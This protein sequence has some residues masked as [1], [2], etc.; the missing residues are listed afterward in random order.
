MVIRDKILHKGT[1][2]LICSILI[3]CFGYNVLNEEQKVYRDVFQGLVE[4]TFQDFRKMSIPPPPPQSP[5][6]SI[7]N[8]HAREYKDKKEMD[9]VFN[10]YRENHKIYLDTT[11]YVPLYVIVSDTLIGKQTKDL[12]NLWLE[13]NEVRFIDTTEIKEDVKIDLSVI[14]LSEDY[15]LKYRSEFSYSIEELIRKDWEQYPKREDRHLHQY[16]GVMYLSRV[17]F[18]STKDLGAFNVGFNCGKL[19]GCGFLVI[20]KKEK[21]IWIIERIKNLG[22]A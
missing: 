13:N 4:K 15:L 7:K 22:C 14:K 17:Y 5:Y 3:G 21:D 19:C 1:I 10:Q 9:S 12:K 6:D 8:E 2:F 20:V 11:V 16:S 18:N